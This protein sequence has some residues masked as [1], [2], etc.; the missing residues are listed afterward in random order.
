MKRLIMCEGPNELAIMRIL[1]A[2]DKLVFGEDDLIGLTPFHARQIKGNAQVRT[3]LNMYPGN[4]VLVMRIGDAQN[5]KL[6]I[7]ADYKEKISNT[8]KYCTKPE[9]EMLL[10]ISEGLTAEYEKVKSTVT[11]KEF[12]KSHIRLG[13]KWYDNST[14]FFKDY[15]ENNADGLVTA[16]REYK[17]IKGSHKKGELYLADLL[18]E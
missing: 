12:A 14:K 11:P 1:I 10:I 18:K 5:E 2:Q 8:E 15:Y 17:R 13:R 9:L 7:P 4:D 16:I 6:T 3:E